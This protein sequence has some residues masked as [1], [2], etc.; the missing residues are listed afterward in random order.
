MLRRKERPLIR[1]IMKAVRLRTVRKFLPNDKKRGEKE[2]KVKT[3]KV[4][5]WEKKGGKKKNT[6]VDD[7]Y[8]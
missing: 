4:F 8:S 7:I 3:Q 6:E 1:Y 5:L 2:K